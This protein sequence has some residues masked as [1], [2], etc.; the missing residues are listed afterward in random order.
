[1][2]KFF[3]ATLAI[4]IL[5]ARA[6]EAATPQLGYQAEFEVTQS[7]VSEKA[8]S[9]LEVIDNSMSRESL[10][11]KSSKVTLDKTT[12][13]Q[14]EMSD[15]D[16]VNQDVVTDCPEEGGLIETITVPA[17]T[18]LTCKTVRSENGG[19]LEIWEG[20]V[21]FNSIKTVRTMADGKT[22]TQLLMGYGER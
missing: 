8:Y 15:F 1:M 3:Y 13:A 4:L 9:K 14:V 19:K 5:S 10:V 16:V 22:E 21:P 6:V 12:V 7:G 20:R 17:G 11:V 18:F 2:A